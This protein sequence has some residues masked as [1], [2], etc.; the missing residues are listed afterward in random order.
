MK[1][2]GLYR[3]IEG[4]FH[5]LLFAYAF[6]DEPVQIVDLASGEKLPQEVVDAIFDENVIKAAW[7][8]QF[9][10]T[11]LSK[12]FGTQLSPDSWRC[13]MVHS[14]S[15]SLPLAL[16]TAAKVLKVSEQ[17]DNAGE[18]LIKYYSMPCKPTKKNGGRTRNLPEHEEN[19]GDWQKF[20]DYCLQDVRTERAIRKKLERFPMPEREWIYYHMDQRINDRGVLIDT[21]LVS[22]AI[23]CDQIQTEIMT[24]RAYE[25][26]GLENPNSVSQ[27]KSWLEER[28]IPVETLGKKD[29][30]A[31][32]TDLDKNSTDQEALDMLKLRLQMAKSSIKK[33]QAAERCTCADGRARGLF[34][35]SGANRTQRWC[36]AEGTPILVKTQSGLITEKAI[37][38]VSIS[39]MV[40]DGNEWVH[41]DGVVFSGDQEV[42]TW[43]GITA[44]PEHMV[45]IDDKNKIPLGDAMEMGVK[46]WRGNNLKP[47]S[48][49]P[50]SKIDELM[51]D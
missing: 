38:D 3:Y 4:D 17:K 29:V 27:L 25:L 47:Q 13:S 21:E 48:K 20:K 37:E 10:R 31:L 14:A 44:T 26:T 18:R 28:G 8:A 12:Y 35:F 51:Q 46:I 34:Q 49:I 33:Y 30:A 2:C 36:L 24:Q 23:E 32:I 50:Q 1:T 39:D 40:F 19:P 9:E 5:I 6:D 15:L 16:K 43:D 42:I 7:N 22:R 45:F 11:C 41:H